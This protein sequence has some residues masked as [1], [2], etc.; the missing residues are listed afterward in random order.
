MRPDK[1]IDLWTSSAG[2][3][4][5][6]EC[7][8]LIRNFRSIYHSRASVSLVNEPLL[9]YFAVVGG[10][11]SVVLASFSVG[12][13]A[14]C[15]S[16]YMERRSRHS[17][18]AKRPTDEAQRMQRPGKVSNQVSFHDYTYTSTLNAPYHD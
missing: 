4:A 7:L 1:Y 12:V 13:E 14:D 17:S 2:V 8:D 10:C 9:A 11:F 5:P 16:W 15:F 18:G 3:L 6:D